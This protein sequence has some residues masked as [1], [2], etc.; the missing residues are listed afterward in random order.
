MKVVSAALAAAMLVAAPSLTPGAQAH[1]MVYA[2]LAERVSPAVVNIFTTQAAP[3]FSGQGMPDLPEGHPL[4][5][6]FKRFGGMQGGRGGRSAE[7]ER[8]LGSGFI[9]DPAGYVITNHHVI[10]KADTIKIAPQRRARVRRHRHRLG[11][12]DRRGPA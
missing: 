1:G 12:G 6:F 10:D 8:S 3:E 9:F 7:P 2:D 5:D 11:R 4:A